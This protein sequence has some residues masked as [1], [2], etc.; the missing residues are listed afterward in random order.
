M[1][2]MRC[3]AL[4]DRMG[5]TTEAELQIV[6]YQRKSHEDPLSRAARRNQTIQSPR[7]VP[8]SVFSTAIFM[9]SGDALNGK[10]CKL[11]F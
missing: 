7:I 4:D 6:L 1:R 10:R 8:A 11:L 9:P 5:T 2:N 3:G